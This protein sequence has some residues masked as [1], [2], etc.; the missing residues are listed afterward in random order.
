MNRNI[1]VV[2]PTN[3][4]ESI[5]EFLIAWDLLFKV[6]KCKVYIV[7]DGNEPDVEYEGKKY[8]VGEVMGKYSH[9]IY[10]F[11]DGVRNLGFA[12]A[13]QDGAEII[14]SLDDD[15]RPIEDRDAIQEHIDA[16]DIKVQNDWLNT[17]NGN[18]M[19]RGIPYGN[20][21]KE[22]VL[23][24]GGWVGVADMDAST[25]LLLGE[26]DFTMIKTTVPKG[27]L[28]PMCIMNVAFK[29]CMTPFMYQAPMAYKA[30]IEGHNDLNRFADIWG[31]IEAKGS[32][33]QNGWA[34]VTG[35][36]IVNH[37]RASNPF[38]NLVKEAEGIGMNEHYGYGVY[39]D[40]YQENRK[41]WQQFLND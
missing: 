8:S 34:C 37:Q 15:V 28:F 10:N 5:N 18:V 31:G 33:D 23:S 4:P 22:V 39:F 3:R 19:M 6:H 40:T 16:L 32:I 7:H 17:V 2:I 36:S 35:Y 12:K 1:S 26:R 14:I 11:N 13:Y 20:R 30:A 38:K 24:H 9:L 29:R 27:V 21:N 41:H 25:Q